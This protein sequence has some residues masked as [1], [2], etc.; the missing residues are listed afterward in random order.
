M[1]NFFS[2]STIIAVISSLFRSAVL[3]AFWLFLPLFLPEV[4]LD[5]L[6]YNYALSFSLVA[7]LD[8]G[9]VSSIA[10]TKIGNSNNFQNNKSLGITIIILQLFTLIIILTFLHFLIDAS[11]SY[12]ITLVAVF[13]YFVLWSSIK[14]I[15][16]K[17]KKNL[18]VYFFDVIIISTSVAGFFLLSGIIQ[19]PITSFVIIGFSSSILYLFVFRK[20]T[21]L[22]I[23]NYFSISEEIKYLMRLNWPLLLSSFGVFIVI[24]IEREFLSN[25]Q[26]GPERPYQ[27]ILTVL[28]QISQLFI[29][30]LQGLYNRIWHYEASKSNELDSIPKYMDNISNL[31]SILSPVGLLIVIYLIPDLYSISLGKQELFLAGIMGTLALAVQLIS[32]KVGSLGLWKTIA[33]YSI[34]SLLINLM[35]MSMVYY[36]ISFGFQFFVL[37]LLI[38]KY[39]ILSIFQLS[40]LVFVLKKASLPG[41][42]FTFS[43]LIKKVIFLVI[44]LFLVSIVGWF[45]SILVIVLHFLI[46]RKSNYRTLK[47]ILNV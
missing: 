6:A 35:I 40:Y 30:A 42:K 21:N 32:I 41:T 25:F 34:V 23:L 44:C 7:L 27:Y 36:V 47:Y 28:I 46:N 45:Y 38:M 26:D 15:T 13:S 33:S 19:N 39:I 29:I 9:G 20:K 24:F 5:I 14:K 1:I 22:F 12:L 2:S 43:I 17:T 4:E 16:E 18:A 31:L 8:L 3:F 37:E 11:Y 10:L